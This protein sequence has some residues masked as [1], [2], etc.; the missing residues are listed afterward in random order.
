ML[1]CSPRLSHVVGAA[2]LWWYVSWSAKESF[3]GNW[4]PGSM[5]FLLPH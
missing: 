5:C 1:G 3:E 2:F 4:L